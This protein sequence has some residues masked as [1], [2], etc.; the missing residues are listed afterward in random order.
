[1]PHVEDTCT[2]DVTLD[3]LF[4][5]SPAA[6]HR[7]CLSLL[8]S[9]ITCF[10][11]LVLDSLRTC[12]LETIAKLL[13]ESYSLLLPSWSICQNAGQTN[14]VP[15]NWCPLGMLYC[16]L[17]HYLANVKSYERLSWSLCSL[18][19]WYIHR[20]WWSFWA[21][22]GFLWLLYILHH[23]RP[24]HLTI[25]AWTNVLQSATNLSSSRLV[26]LIYI[27]LYY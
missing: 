16:L 26:C 12:K 5:Y 4:I 25:I 6:Y 19:L 15:S 11:L 13:A 10:T 1:M 9:R 7:R 22:L 20:G 14:N 3:V 24:P 21:K 18:L 17:L 2:E 8:T 23:R 27:I